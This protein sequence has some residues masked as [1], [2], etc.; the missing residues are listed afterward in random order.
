[1]KSNLSAWKYVRNNKKSVATMI[2][3]LALSFAVIYIVHV[4]LMTSV[5]GFKPMLLEFPKKVGF[6]N[7][8]EKT[9]E[10]SKVK[11]AEN[12]DTKE[13]MQV[14][15][16]TLRAK[17]GVKD[18]TWAQ[19]LKAQLQAVIGMWSEEFPLYTT[20]EEIERYLDH[21]G[22]KLVKGRLP[23]AAGEV[24]ISSMVLKNRKMQ[25]GD[26][27]RKEVFGETFRI[28][29]E[30]ESDIMVSAGM[31]NHNYNSGSY[32][33]IQ[34]DEEN[35][36]L[37]AFFTEMGVELNAGDMVLDLPEHREHFREDCDELIADIVNTISAVVMFFVAVT[38]LIAYVSFLRNRVNE[39][40]LYASI[41]YRRW[42]VYGM[43]M[44]EMTII[45]GIGFLLGM[46]MALPTAL[47]VKTAILDPA[48]IVSV[49]WYPVMIA[50]LGAIM[51]LIL[52]LLQIPVLVSIRKI[53]TIDEIE[54]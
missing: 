53:K 27:F 20:T 36:D 10:K 42:E 49:A 9:L 16:D 12:G 21:T 47:I 7:I 6:V 51:L 17:E 1:M 44:R 26:W 14:L 34:Y 31:P 50:K 19:V 43:M 35:A 40:C 30:V 38:M 4:L 29:G 33:V 5:E 8:S 23:E 45:F 13:K 52:G 22:A 25:V 18:I 24:V 39:Y 54:D 3:A 11:G 28:V 2:S 37:T 48:G 15:L 32:Y 46:V 41:G